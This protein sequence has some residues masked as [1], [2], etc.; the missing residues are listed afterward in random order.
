MISTT[1]NKSYFVGLLIGIPIAFPSVPFYL[2]SFLAFFLSVNTTKLRS[3]YEVGYVMAIAIV[4]VLTWISNALSPYIGFIEPMNWV[5]SSVV[6]LFFSIGLMITEPRNV[7]KG[8]CHSMSVISVILIV[9]FIIL[10]PYE[11]GVLMFVYPM[12]RMWG[13]G[14]LPDWPNFIAFGL[15]L[16]FLLSYLVT[17][18]KKIAMLNLVAA[19]L[20]TSRIP[21]LALMLLIGMR[22]VKR[23]IMAVAIGVIVVL[24]FFGLIQ[25]MEL[26]NYEI[27]EINQLI[28]RLGKTKDR[29]NLFSYMFDELFLNNP[30]TGIGSVKMTIFNL[31]FNSSSYHN[32]YL[33][34]LVRYGSLTMIPYL[35]LIYPRN[36]LDFKNDMIKSNYSYLVIASFVLFTAFFQNILK[37]PHYLMMYSVIILKSKEIFGNDQFYKKNT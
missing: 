34:I 21:I 16:S 17:R 19:I 7:I 1:T 32:S 25:V 14:Y 3:T 12:F 22:F 2:F 23:P 4:I 37:H 8:F 15:S 20:T 29:E 6:F 18:N 33:E 35:F 10:H 11:H 13:E 27:P 30:L 9:A 24:L 5:T 36:I 28:D 26:M 31:N